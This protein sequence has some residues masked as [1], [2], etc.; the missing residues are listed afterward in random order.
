MPRMALCGA[1]TIGVDISEPN[2]PPLVMVNVPPV[3]S[4]IAM[5]ALARL[6]GVGGDFFFDLGEALG[7]RIAHDRHHEAAIRGDRNA[8]VVVLVVD[9]VGAVHGCVDDR[10]FLQRLDARPSRRTT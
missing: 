4:S 5:R 3:R 9:D 2:T 6:A 1:L 10:E 8:D 7:I